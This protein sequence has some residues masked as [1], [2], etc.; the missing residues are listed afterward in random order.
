MENDLN[1]NKDKDVN[2]FEM[3]IRVLGGFLS[4]YHLTGDNLFKT[5]AVS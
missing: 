2:L 3:T 5:K 4:A 1:L